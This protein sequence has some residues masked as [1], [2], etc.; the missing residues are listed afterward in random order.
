MSQTLSQ[1]LR[2]TARQAVID[3]VSEAAA[4]SHRRSHHKLHIYRDGEVGWTTHLN[5]S[6][7]II[8]R[9]AKHFAAVPSVICVGTGSYVCNCDYCNEVYSAVDEALAAEQGR[10][11]DKSAKY[12]DENEAILDAVADSDLSDL[13]ACMLAEFDAIPA[14]YFQDE[15]L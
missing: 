5:Q 11:Y 9:G 13:E 4:Y 2:D 12:A 8:D 1:T 6:D 15:V 7:D 3:A 14:G 10:K